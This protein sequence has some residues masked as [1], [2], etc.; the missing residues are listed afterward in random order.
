MPA[1]EWPVVSLAAVEAARGLGMT[2]GEVEKLAQLALDSSGV[3]PEQR[4]R[5]T[6][7]WSFWTTMAGEL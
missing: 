6:R 7:R 4:L 3:S 1:N 2:R 5:A